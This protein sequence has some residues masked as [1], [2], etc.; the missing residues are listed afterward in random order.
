MTRRSRQARP[1]RSQKL[2]GWRRSSSPQAVAGCA[3]NLAG[4]FFG[5]LARGARP[6]SATGLEGLK[7]L[8]R[9]C[10]GLSLFIGFEAPAKP[11]P[12]G[13]FR[14]LSGPCRACQPGSPSIQ[15]QARKLGPQAKPKSKPSARLLCTGPAAS[16]LA[17][18]QARSLE[19]DPTKPCTRLV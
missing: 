13:P 9:A 17:G 12:A 11:A 7:G 15:E 18:F 3:V 8:S 14:D 16:G 6:C 2:S 4:C 5:A 1:L 10:K 19:P